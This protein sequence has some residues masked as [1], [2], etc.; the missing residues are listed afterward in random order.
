MCPKTL[1]GLDGRSG[2]G[3]ATDD[4]EVL[5]ALRCGEAST[6]LQL[7]RGELKAMTLEGLVQ[8]WKVRTTLSSLH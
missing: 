1:Q 2:S 5:L 3:A 8:I 4:L 7:T 6:Q